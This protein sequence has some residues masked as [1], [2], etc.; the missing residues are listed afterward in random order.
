MA[1]ESTYA[2]VRTAGG[3]LTDFDFPFPFFSPSDILVYTIDTSTTPE[4]ATLKTLTTH[5]IL[6][7]ANGVAISQDGFYEG[8]TVRFTAAV[9]GLDVFIGRDIDFTQPTDVPT[10]G[11]FREQTLERALDRLAMQVQQIDNATTR[12]LLLPVTSETG[13]LELP[14]PEANKVLGWNSAGTGLENKDAIDKSYL[15][16]VEAARDAAAASESN[17]ANSETMAEKWAEEDEDTEV[18]AGKYSAKHYAAKAASAYIT[19]AATSPA[20]PF[21]GQQWYDSKLH[22]LKLYTGTAW[23][24]LGEQAGVTKTF[25]GAAADVP[26][27]YLLCYGQ[28]I[29]REDYAELF[30]A[31][32]TVHGV[33]DGSTTFNLPDRRGRTIAGYDNMGGTGANVITDAQADTDGGKMGAETVA[34]AAHT[35]SVP[36]DGWGIITAD[37]TWGRLLTQGS[38]EVVAANDNTTGSAGSATL[39]TV[40]PTA[41]SNVIIKI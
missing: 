26:D 9:S 5:Y 12:S 16:Q 41:F 3:G 25:D 11:L 38:A 7:D 1:I 32:G 30:A 22:V 8:G 27:G 15:A 40:Q 23:I 17:S 18:E 4:T 29:S 21:T 14:E 19:I 36:R 34:L 24:R 13:D 10:A 35:H 6:L 31:I 20:A 33:G 37:G 2:P 28:A 39:A